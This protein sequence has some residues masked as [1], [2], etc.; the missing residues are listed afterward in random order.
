MALTSAGVSM[1]S[2]IRPTVGSTYSPTQRPIPK[3]VELV[4]KGVHPDLV[5]AVDPT[6]ANR[7]LGDH[8]GVLQYLQ[9]LRHGGA[10]HRQVGGES[11][12]H[13][14]EF[15]K[16]EPRVPQRGVGGTFAG[17]VDPTSEVATTIFER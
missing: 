17:E 11:S 13:A 14:T 3:G 8:P 9:M 10:A 5:E 15:V 12:P 4:A 6:R 7:L 16:S 1:V 2:R